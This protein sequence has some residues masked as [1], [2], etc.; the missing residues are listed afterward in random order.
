MEIIAKA[1]GTLETVFCTGPIPLY[2]IRELVGGEFEFIHLSD[3]TVLAR[4]KDSTGLE[5]NAHYPFVQGDVLVG[6]MPGDDFVGV[7]GIE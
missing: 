6:K 7:F 1:N 2:R 3:H 5:P 4:R